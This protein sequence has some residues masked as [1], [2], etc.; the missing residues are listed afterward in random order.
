MEVHV[1]LNIFSDTLTPEKISELTGIDADKFWLA[2]DRR[3]DTQIIEKE[4]GWAIKSF[5]NKDDDLEAH[6]QD[7]RRRLSGKEGI[8]KS[9]SELAGCDIQLSGVIYG[10]DTPA[11]CFDKDVIGWL[12]SIGASLDID[13]YNIDTD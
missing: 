4:N 5:L 13:I 6:I 12:G 11:L 3:K 9:I 1:N 2:G 8:I 7:M 10:S